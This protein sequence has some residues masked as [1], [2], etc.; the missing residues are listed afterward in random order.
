MPVRT[1][2]TERE[3][4]DAIEHTLASIGDADIHALTRVAALAADSLGTRFAAVT[5]V[6]AAM[7]HFVAAHGFDFRVLPRDQFFC[8]TTVRGDRPFFV[9]DASVDPRFAHMTVVS[10]ALGLRFYAGVPLRSQRGALIGTLCVFDQRCD[11]FGA[12]ERELLISLAE[13]ATRALRGIDAAL[14]FPAVPP[15]SGAFAPSPFAIPDTP[16]HGSELARGRGPLWTPPAGVDGD[17][18]P[19]WVRG[20]ESTRPNAR[21]VSD[22]LAAELHQHP[23]LLQRIIDSNP[24]PVFIKNTNDVFVMANSAGAALFGRTAEQLIGQREADLVVDP[25]NDEISGSF[26]RVTT[27]VQVATGAG[28]PREE[29]FVDSEGRR[30]FFQVHRQC[31]RPSPH[32]ARYILTIATETTAVKTLERREADRQDLTRVV[33]GSERLAVALERVAEFV[34][35]HIPGT[36]CFVWTRR[37]T[38]VRVAC[39]DAAPLAVAAQ[40]RSRVCPEAKI[41]RAGSAPVAARLHDGAVDTSDVCAPYIGAVEHYGYSRLLSRPI[42]NAAGAVIGALDVLSDTALVSTDEVGV[43]NDA[44]DLASIAIEQRRRQSMLSYQAQYDPLTR[45]PN[46]YELEARVHRALSH[47]RRHGHMVGLLHID[48]DRFKHVNDTLGHAVGDALLREVAGRFESCL[49]TSD[50]LARMAGDEFAAVLTEVGDAAGA[51]R[52]AQKL[53]DALHRPFEI[54]GFSLVVTATIGIAMFPN[55][56]DD[57][58]T[59]L[60]NAAAALHSAKASSSDTFRFFAPNI[61]RT[62]LE[63]LELQTALREAITD[64]G[65]QLHL[66]PQLDVRTG[67]TVGFEALARWKHETHGWVSPNKFIPLAEETRLIVEIGQWALEESCRAL[68]TWLDDGGGPVRVG[69]NVSPTQLASDDFVSS[70]AHT[71]A[72]F[73]IPARMLELEITENAMV[74]DVETVVPKLAALR[75]LGVAIAIDDFGT[76]YSNLVYLEELPIDRVKIDRAFVR[77]I[78]G[79]ADQQRKGGRMVKAIIHMA[80]TFD[81]EVIAE[82]VETNDQLMFLRNAGCEVAQGYLY[83]RP[84]AVDEALAVVRDTAPRFDA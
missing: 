82:G 57:A 66:Q 39:T 47:G 24:N 21:D 18:T 22:A 10:G 56:G 76:G 19:F 8:G 45:L 17:A 4:L 12:N 53:M 31:L 67:R 81:L 16:T 46:R 52:V 23:E 7:T 30:R 36:L 29:Q 35:D 62:A 27:D 63:R 14:G 38:E 33:S 9:L 61:H 42:R 51:T 74:E 71:L 43:L 79:S 59:L 26:E 72:R 49:R 65:L 25:D 64:R 5:L 69:V 75:S 2:P 32:G 11:D 48:L 80:H 3:R 50:S 60:R 1:N 83:H 55:D 28:E 41:P 40:V 58:A 68:R 84:M 6:D 13:Q 34:E 37:G 44:N 20:E 73:G 77:R 15:E 78:Q 54:A 70:V